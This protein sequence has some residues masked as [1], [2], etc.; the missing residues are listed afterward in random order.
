MSQNAE[1]SPLHS[2]SPQ[3]LL[4]LRGVTKRFGALIANDKVDLAL[5]PG[6]IHAVVGENG[7]GKST[8]MKI[9]YGMIQ[10]NEGDLYVQGQKCS[11]WSSPAAAI[12]NGIGMVH[13]HFMLAGPES[14]LSNAVLGDETRDSRWSFLPRFLRPMNTTQLKTRLQK[15][16]QEF[17]FDMDWDAPVEA[18]PVGVQQRLEILKLLDRDAKILILDEPT[19]VLTPQETDDFFKNLRKLA[20]R[21]C[22]IVV[23]THKL[24]EVLQFSD[25]VT[26]LRAG[27]VTARLKTQGTTADQLA[28]A[29]VGRK[30]VLR[31]DQAHSERRNP[32]NE[33]ALEA[34][35]LVLHAPSEAKGS[36][37]K[38]NHLSFQLKRGEVLGIA[39]VE[40]NGQSELLKALIHPSD[41]AAL[42]SGAVLLLGEEVQKK[43]DS[44]IRD[45][46]LAVI[47]EDRHEEGLL[48]DSTLTENYLLGLQR[49]R[50]FSSWGWLNVNELDREVSRALD[51]HDIRPRRADATARSLSGG[52]QQKWLIAREFARQPKVLIASQPTRGVDVGAIEAI[53]SRI[54]KARDEGLGVLLISSEL[55]EVMAL[56]DRILVLYEGKCAAEFHRKPGGAPFDERAIGLAMSGVSS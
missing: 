55:D 8:L 20:D 53:H 14:A 44:F 11:W 13:Q 23:I 30:V 56:S 24:R 5:F 19:A 31:V 27:R 18:L 36:K 28:E 9:A 4:E 49:E 45:L 38:L 32:S 3:P 12:Q 22:A 37:L 34:R 35:D 33:I 46:G 40:G 41:R 54:L 16:A 42:S 26:V 43:S 25:E 29:M 2:S 52:N 51:E 47:P 48:L 50:R 10:P 7:A 39:G 17:Q 21:G 15:R 6:R 1:S